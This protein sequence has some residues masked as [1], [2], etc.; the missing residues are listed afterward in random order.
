MIPAERATDLWSLRGVEPDLGAVPSRAGWSWR[1]DYEPWRPLFALGLT[2]VPGGVELVAAGPPPAPPGDVDRRTVP[3]PSAEADRL[4]MATANLPNS[5]RI[6]FAS[7][8]SWTDARFAEH[9]LRDWSEQGVLVVVA[10]H[11]RVAGSSG[12]AWHLTERSSVPVRAAIVH[13]TAHDCAGGAQA[14]ARSP[15]WFWARA[16]RNGR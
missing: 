8:R 6:P 7:A 16:G 5:W 11:T 1:G 3:L 13:A 9:A 12:V 10:D 14:W 2:E 15:S 4:A